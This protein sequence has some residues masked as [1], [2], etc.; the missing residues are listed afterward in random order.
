MKTLW[1]FVLGMLFSASPVLKSVFCLCRSHKYQYH[2]FTILCGSCAEQ[3][4]DTPVYPIF[5]Y[6]KKPIPRFL[7]LKQLKIVCYITKQWSLIWIVTKYDWK[8]YFSFFSEAISRCL[9]LIFW[10]LFLQF[11]NILPVW[12]S[13]LLCHCNC[14]VEVLQWTQLQKAVVLIIIIHL[15]AFVG[16]KIDILLS[17]SSFAKIIVNSKNRIS[18]K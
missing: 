16:G 2:I 8:S 10:Y 12:S 5:A 11:S 14:I 4:N 7:G 9:T 13:Q 15:K 17:V 18:N 6:R 3:A 1:E